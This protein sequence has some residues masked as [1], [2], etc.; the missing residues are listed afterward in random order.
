MPPPSTDPWVS[1]DP[2]EV[3]DR[4]LHRLV[5]IRSVWFPTP[6]ELRRWD[7]AGVPLYIVTSGLEVEIGPRLASMWAAAFSPVLRG[8]LVATDGGTRLELR[9][10]WPRV[11]LGVLAVWWTVV[12]AWGGMLLV[13]VGQRGESP[14]LAVWWG[15]L[16]AAT[17]LGP[18]VGWR[19]GGQQLDAALPWLVHT[20]GENRVQG[21]DW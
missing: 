16:V 12:L 1:G 18:W 15:I 20:A 21:E 6:K 3:R 7:Q 9:R 17:T 14:M 2:A 8:Q 5:R 13:V 11:T 19:L 10:T 4:L